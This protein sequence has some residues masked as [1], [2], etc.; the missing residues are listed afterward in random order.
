MGAAAK[1]FPPFTAEEDYF[2]R[3]RDSAYLE[4]LTMVD[5]GPA[6]AGREAESTAWHHRHK[7]GEDYRER[8]A[9]RL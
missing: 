7:L 8:R 3:L 4:I 1:D 9:A 2:Y 5:G 6:A